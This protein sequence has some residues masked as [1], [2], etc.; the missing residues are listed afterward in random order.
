MVFPRVLK[1]R[2]RSKSLAASYLPTNE[3]GKLCKTLKIIRIKG[4]YLLDPGENV[5]ASGW[6][7]VRLSGF[8]AIVVVDQ[9]R[10]SVTKVS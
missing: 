5:S 7:F 2:P 8:R 1:S 9:E 4:V 3:I 10:A 6:R